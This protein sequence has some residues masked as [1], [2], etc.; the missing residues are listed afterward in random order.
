MALE[1]GGANS[2]A[3][4]RLTGRF[5]LPGA[6]PPPAPIHSPNK[7]AAL[8]QVN[9]PPCFSPV[10]SKEILVSSHRPVVEE[11]EEEGYLLDEDVV[12]RSH[13]SESWLWQTELL[14]LEADHN[15]Y[16]IWTL[17]G[18][19][20][21]PLAM[22]PPT[23]PLPTLPPGLSH[24]GGRWG[25]CSL[26]PPCAHPLPLLSPGWLPARCPSIWRTPSPPGK[27][28]L[29]ASQAQRVSYGKGG[30][31]A[32]GCGREFGPSREWGAVVRARRVETSVPSSGKGMRPSC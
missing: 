7:N 27:C 28:W 18:P 10:M 17:V 16:P 5:S 12:T 26:Q 8:Y 15:G 11:E 20:L 21:C 14:P 31:Q 30:L 22:P 23:L 1:I 29:S 4:L 32:L 9:A 19:S 3:G 2:T 6:A 24:R 25:L 13:F